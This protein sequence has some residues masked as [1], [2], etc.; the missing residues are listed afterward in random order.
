MS[1]S[2][3]EVLLESFPSISDYEDLYS[4]YIANCTFNG[5]LSYTA[6][7]FNIVAIHAITKTSS[8]PNPL[9]TLLVS[10]AVSDVGVG[11]LVQP[12]YISLLV[13]WLQ[14]SNTECVIYK[15]LTAI[16]GFFSAASFFG[17]MVISMDRFL[18]IHFHLRYQELV[19]HK[20]VV[21]VV[22]TVWVLSAVLSVPWSSTTI[23]HAVIA[24]VG[25]A[26]LLLTAVAYG[27]IYAV[28]RRHQNQIQ[29]LQ[30]SFKFM[31]KKGH[32]GAVLDVR[33]QSIPECNNVKIAV[34]NFGF[35][36]YAVYCSLK[37]QSTGSQISVNIMNLSNNKIK[38]IEQGTFGQF[39]GLINLS[40]TYNNIQIIQKDAFSG[41]F[42][43]EILNLTGNKLQIWN[44]HGASLHLPSL[45]IID[46]QGNMGWRPEE[47]YLLELPR[48]KEIRN[49]SWAAE[50]LDC[51]LIKKVRSNLVEKF[52]NSHFQTQSH[53]EKCSTK[54]L[55]FS[56]YLVLLARHR[57]VVTKC[58]SLLDCIER[59]EAN[60]TKSNPCWPTSQR[61]LSMQL[62]F[63]IIGSCLNLVVFFNI[64]LTKSLR[65]NVSMVLV[66][67]LALGD[68]LICMYSAIMA[69]L[70]VS[71]QY[72][73][74]YEHLG[75]ISDVQCP[76]VGSLW[77]LG[78]LTT[79]I[80]S[81]A[82]TLERYLCIVFSM[83]PGIR[84]TPRLASLAIAFNWVVAAS[85][86]SFA[87]YFDLYHNTFVCIPVVFDTSRPPVETFYTIALFSLGI[88][89]YLVT[90]PLY[91]HIYRVVKTI[92]S[93]NGSTARVYS[94]QANCR[95]SRD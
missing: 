79:S 23:H 8:L 20:R 39:S 37:D 36:E 58:R 52:N 6:I 41:L 34:D 22:I 57:F 27:R 64:L 61:V 56:D 78:Q 95:P 70:I 21:A 13:K 67:N 59:K 48:L 30:E 71:N 32:R 1:K 74:L 55:A 77:V 19:T 53:R 16:G 38:A 26:C 44:A 85:M 31:F 60:V 87:H 47:K 45:I 90:I 72:E 63:G 14:Q 91:V 17:V 76:R 46:V 88:T 68:T 94:S 83:K 11:L 81:V 51:W 4:T 89:L 10:L 2:S 28:L 33:R 50:C 80:T 24:S 54:Y 29:A 5:F 66:S 62:V 40:L 84:M 12:F 75:S 86:M 82:L 35:T 65:K 7:V 93:A 92:Q 69:G 43:L 42:F 18:A 15:A 49:V 3:C 25:V 73:D 9:K